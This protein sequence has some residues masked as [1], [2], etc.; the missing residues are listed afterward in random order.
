MNS[1]NISST[2]SF[3]GNETKPIVRLTLEKRTKTYASPRPQ[4]KGDI[5]A[6]KPQHKGVILEF[7][8]SN[9]GTYNKSFS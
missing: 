6:N 8:F 1:I 2:T 7:N 3:L 4:H 5:A 9:L